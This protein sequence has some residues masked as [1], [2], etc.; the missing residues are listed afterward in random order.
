MW[1]RRWRAVSSSEP[2]PFSLPLTILCFCTGRRQDDYCQFT[3]SMT[4]RDLCESS[5]ISLCCS[6]V[7]GTVYS[8]TALWKLFP[9]PWLSHTLLTTSF[10][11]YHILFEQRKTQLYMMF[12][13]PVN[14]YLQSNTNLLFCPPS[15]WGIFLLLVTLELTFSCS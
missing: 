1:Q 12:V 8:A 4:L 15:I 11:F 7:G 2:A 3:F 6:M 10:Q 14:V 9:F 13:T 5:P